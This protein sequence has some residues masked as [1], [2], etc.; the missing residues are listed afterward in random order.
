MAF[1]KPLEA[2]GIVTIRRDGYLFLQFYVS[3]RDVRTVS[4]TVTVC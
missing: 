2:G 4:Q 3:V 1:L